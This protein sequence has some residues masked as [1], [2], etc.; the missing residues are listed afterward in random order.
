MSIIEEFNSRMPTILNK[1]T[2]DYLAWFGDVN[3]TP[4][5][6]IEQSS[7]Y[8]C[9][10]I[11]N[12]FE[13]AQ[14]FIDYLTRSSS[15]DDFY[16]EFLERIIYFFTGLQRAYKETD[17]NFRTRFKALCIRK[18][19]PNWI[20]TWMIKDVFSYFF[21]PDI[22][23][24]VENYV[25]DNYI[26]DESMESG[27]W[28]SFQSGSTVV[29]F[30]LHDQFD[31]G[32]CA[33]FQI[34]AT[35]SLGRIEQTLPAVAPIGEYMLSFWLKDDQNLTLSENIAKVF[36]QRDSDSFYYNFETF[37]WQ[38]GIAY[39]EISKTTA[40][41]Y[42]IRQALI[43]MDVEDLLTIS[44]ENIEGTSEEHVFW[45]DFLEL[46]TKVN[47]G[48]V[49]VMLINEGSVSI[50]TSLWEGTNDPV[51]GLDYEL[52]SF[53]DQN[54]IEGFGGLSALE[55]FQSLLNII[56]PYGIETAL[57]VINRFVI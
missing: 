38:S 28:T 53:F 15:I 54:Y 24:V 29:S 41:K 19:N 27:S 16:G 13:Y 20:T 33:E 11:C 48:R 52:A 44:I 36:I 22:I 32:A 47:Y 25:T 9:G 39:W 37:S 26:D 7:D 3:F 6:P 56:K 50:Y 2:T 17:E 43:V 34:D 46:G 35:G 14:G 4:N 8:Q 45:V 31:L 1:T 30:V 42:E 23:Y 5:D 49:K 18:N 51:M 40:N 57:Q 21:D 12:E 55:Y 10:A